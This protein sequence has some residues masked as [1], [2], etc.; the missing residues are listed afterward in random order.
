MMLYHLTLIDCELPNDNPL[1]SDPCGILALLAAPPDRAVDHSPSGETAVSECLP[2]VSQPVTVSSVPPPPESGVALVEPV[3]D[4]NLVTE[5]EDAAEEGIEIVDEFD[6]VE[7]EIAEPCAEEPTAQDPFAMF[8]QTL[9]CVAQDAGCTRAA[10]LLPALLEGGQVEAGA[11]GEPAIDGLVNAGVLA[12]GPSGLVGGESFRRTADAWRAILRGDSDDFGAC[13]PRM[14]DE[15]AADL[16]ARIVAAP[17]KTEQLRRE[18]RTRGVAAFG[19][20][21]AA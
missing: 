10:A 18:L 21:L 5:T 13:G 16:V 11:L 7:F 2:V 8:V 15:W 17:A 6:P 19:L 12:R 20:V 9:V 14:L 1:L 3:H 4:G